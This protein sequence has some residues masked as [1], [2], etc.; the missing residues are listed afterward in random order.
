[1][2]SAQELSN[3]TPGTVGIQR[4]TKHTALSGPQSSYGEIIL[5]R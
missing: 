3:V 2:D 4:W 1:M 5:S